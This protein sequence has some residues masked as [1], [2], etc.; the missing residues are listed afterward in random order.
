MYLRFHGET[1]QHLLINKVAKLIV[2]GHYMLS[3]LCNS[4]IFNHHI[5]SLC[6]LF[7]LRKD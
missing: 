7:E 1:N 6:M 4:I 5:L 3:Y 2:W